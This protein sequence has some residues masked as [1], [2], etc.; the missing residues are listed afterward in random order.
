MINAAVRKKRSKFA[1][2]FL[3]P[4]IIFTFIIGWSLYFIG[5]GSSDT[6]KQKTTKKTL[7]G[8]DNVELIA[9]PVQVQEISAK[10]RN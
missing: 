9:I 8:K 5:T 1:I 6:V 7:V 2:I 3:S 10:Q 4:I